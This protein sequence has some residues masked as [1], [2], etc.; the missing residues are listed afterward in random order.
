MVRIKYLAW[1]VQNWLKG[2]KFGPVQRCRWCG[3]TTPCPRHRQ[4]S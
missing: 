4:R 3:H 2:Y 1:S